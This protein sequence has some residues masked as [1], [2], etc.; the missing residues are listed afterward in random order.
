PDVP[1]GEALLDQRNL[2][3]IGNLYKSEVLFLLGVHP[4]MP[5]GEASGVDNPSQARVSY[6]CPSCQPEP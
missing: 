2:A 6:W 5:A 4:D 1:I 3:G